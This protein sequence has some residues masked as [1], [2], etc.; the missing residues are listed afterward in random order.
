M[1]FRATLKIFARQLF[2]WL[3][4]TTTYCWVLELC[5]AHLVY[6]RAEIIE[7]GSYRHSMALLLLLCLWGILF[8]L[9]GEAQLMPTP[10]AAAN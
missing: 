7:L 3:Y 10:R 6:G 4:I 1:I 8:S 9:I 2:L 5:R